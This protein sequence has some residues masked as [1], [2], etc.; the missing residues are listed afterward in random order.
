MLLLIPLIAG[1]DAGVIT[2]FPSFLKSVTKFF[3]EVALAF[4]AIPVIYGAWQ[5]ITAG[6]DPEKIENGKKMILYA[7]V[8][9]SILLIANATVQ[10]IIDVIS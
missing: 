1:A 8:G 5:L 4:L 9:V 2:D 3:S 10:L 7:F 6:G